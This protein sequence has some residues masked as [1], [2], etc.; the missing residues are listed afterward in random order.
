[1]KQPVFLTALLAL[2]L[3]VPVGVQAAQ[4]DKGERADK[5]ASSSLS[6]QDKRFIDKAMQDNN[7]ELALAKVAL[8]KAQNAEVKSF[9]QR[10]LDDHTKAG[11][12]LEGIVSRLGYTPPK[13]AQEKEPRDAQKFA[14]MSGEKFDREFSKHM[15]K[16][17]E[18]AV[19]LFKDQAQ[20]GQSQELWQFAQKTLP[21]LEEH[22]RISKQLAGDS[23]ERRERKRK[24][25]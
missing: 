22:L 24:A 19:K 20:D 9:A 11:S 14:K 1:M 13:K 12:E 6:R 21:T 15:V 16:D 18:K 2:V 10:L 7:A 8:E 25:S 23:G 3:A 4:R 17:H 5:A